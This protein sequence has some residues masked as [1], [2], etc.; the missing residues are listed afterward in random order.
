M[1]EGALPDQK[2]VI[3]IRAQVG[4]RR[5][6][7]EDAFADADASRPGGGKG[8]PSDP[9]FINQCLANNELGDGILFTA[10]HRGHFIFDASA[11]EW[12]CWAGHHWQRDIT[13]K[14]LAAVEDVAMAYLGEVQRIGRQVSATSDEEEIERLQKR[15]AR[16][17]RRVDRLRSVRGRQNTLTFASTCGEGALVVTGE[18]L[19]ANPWLFP[20]TNG[21][22][23]LRTGQLRS[24]DPEDFM[25]KA[26]TADFPDSCE[27]YLATGEDSPCPAWEAFVKE[28]LKDSEEL[29]AYLSRLFGYGITGLVREHVFAVLFGHGR[30]GKGTLI[31]T[32]AGLLGPLAAPVPAELL[33]D[34]GKVSNPAG[35][36]PHLMALRGLRL[37]F[38]S[39]TDQGRRFS[40]SRVKW[41]SGGDSL[42]GRHPH[43]RQPTT[44]SPS[45]L[46]CLA[47]NH[48]PK[49]DASDFAFWSRLH[50]VEFGLS[51]VERPTADHERQIDKTLSEKLR[52]EGPGI[53]AWLVRGCLQWQHQGLNPPAAILA[54][55]AE[56]RQSEDDLFAW[57]EERCI[58]AEDAIITAKAAY[59][60]FREWWIANVSDK[61]PSQKRFGD[62]M[63]RRGFSKDRGGPGGSFR[64]T[65]LELRV[66]A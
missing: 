3:D 20:C 33:L 19:D 64:Y 6:Q 9:D 46:L 42:T 1:T 41:L 37:A 47:T 11:G 52:Q 48:K 36:S 45:H 39:E 34:Q 49:A 25:T 10:I 54:A 38:C 23:D 21:V 56:Y 2:K 27:E 26:A 7:E 53:L 4:A 51:Y 13:G 35:P 29:A 62:S 55:T 28:I 16:I 22:V 8:G 65:G 32:L 12:L 66:L 63:S 57:I 30:N 58:E 50:L 15:Q 17:L 59:Q 44:F 61:P 31:E 14:A 18:Q 60:S 5:Q 40:A 43:D 24:G